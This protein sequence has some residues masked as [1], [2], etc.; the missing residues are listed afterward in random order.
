MSKRR[1]KTTAEPR[2]ATDEP[3]MSRL[4]V[5]CSKNNTE[6]DFRN[7]FSK[8][9]KFKFLLIA[10]EF[11]QISSS[12]RIEE[13]RILKDRDGTSKGVAYIKF[14]KTSEAATACESMNGEQIGDS[15]RPIK[16]LIAASRQMGAASA[17]SR[18]EE[19]A[20]RL[21]IITPKE[22]T[23]D[24]LYEQF[25]KYGPIDDVTIVRDRKTRDGKQFAYIKFKK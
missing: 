18:E 14:S 21:F 15:A 1:F 5:V 9:G 23:E 16:V 2:D 17:K 24:T 11:K 25:G 3:P 10:I 13:I 6:E 8:F 12:G 4:F 19:K 7:S 20:Q 22:F